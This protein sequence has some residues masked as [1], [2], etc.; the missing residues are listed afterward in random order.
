LENGGKQAN[1]TMNAEQRKKR[2]LW[3]PDMHHR[4]DAAR[5][6]KSS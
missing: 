2:G 1:S 6:K 3:R 5:R 4:L